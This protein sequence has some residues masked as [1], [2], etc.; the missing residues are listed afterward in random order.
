MESEAKGGTAPGRPGI[1]PRWTSSRKSGV[2]TA[3][4]IESHLWFSIS[5]GIVNEIY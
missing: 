1:T 4:N 5:H 2:G 3:T